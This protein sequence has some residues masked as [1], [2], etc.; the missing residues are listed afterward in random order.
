METIRNINHV[1]LH[2]RDGAKNNGGN[3]AA[4]KFG[5]NCTPQTIEHFILI[6]MFNNF[7]KNNYFT[8]HWNYNIHGK[9]CDV[10]VFAVIVN[11]IVVHFYSNKG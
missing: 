10:K 5:R 8:Y 4:K 2:C 3:I 6:Y 1:Y 9:D 7:M 11:K